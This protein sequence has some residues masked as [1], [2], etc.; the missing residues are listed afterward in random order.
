VHC[1]SRRLPLSP[2]TIICNI[3]SASLPL[4]KHRRERLA[5]DPRSVY[6]ERFQRQSRK[7]WNWAPGTFPPPRKL[8]GGQ[9]PALRFLRADVLLERGQAAGRE[10]YMIVSQPRTCCKY[11]D[12]FSQNM[13]LSY[14]RSRACFGSPPIRRFIGSRE[15]IVER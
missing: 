2:V 3:Q 7:A 4:R 12:R 15:G 8:A 13:V 9:I 10:I 14:V 11:S 5:Q 6:E 1:Q